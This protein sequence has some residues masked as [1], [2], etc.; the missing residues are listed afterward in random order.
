MIMAKPSRAEHKDKDRDDSFIEK[1]VSV[2]RVTKVVK[3][4]KNMRFAA[5]VVVGDGKGRASYA[6]GKAREVPDAVKK[7]VDRAK[8]SL[9]RIP[10]RE[11]RTLHHDI[12]ASIGASTV[13][14]RTAPPGTGVIAGG[15]L[16]AIFEAL[17]VH[18]VV[19]KSVGTA[20][21]H[22]T[23]RATFLAL[24]KIT[25]PKMVAQKLG[26]KV[27]DVI[28]RRDPVHQSIV[29]QQPVLPKTA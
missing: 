2:R 18:D 8:K 13:Y 11:G 21:Y 27:S 6:T 12:S 28:A 29:P 10:L 17:G 26:K 23:V 4:G 19:A 25:S 14:L 7:A 3:G 15:A 1:L 22:N 9:V 16:R 24:S 20:T 5:L